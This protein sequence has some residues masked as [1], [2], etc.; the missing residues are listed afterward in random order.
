MLKDMVRQLFDLFS[1]S[2]QLIDPVRTRQ[3][4][5]CYPEPYVALFLIKPKL[6]N[7]LNADFFMRLKL[8]PFGELEQ[9]NFLHR[10][11]LSCLKLDINY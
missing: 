5:T 1:Y 8:I 4:N 10:N 9:R 6:N 3:Y 7:S 2:L 11:P